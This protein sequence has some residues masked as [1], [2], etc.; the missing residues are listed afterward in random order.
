MFVG[1]DGSLPKTRRQALALPP[2]LDLARLD[3]LARE[4]LSSLFENSLITA[5][6][7]FIT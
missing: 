7:S 4:K 2:T 5:V 6:K 3:R 1:K